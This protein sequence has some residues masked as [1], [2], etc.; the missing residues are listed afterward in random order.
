MEETNKILINKRLEDISK[1]IQT[2]NN[3]IQQYIQAI[4]ELL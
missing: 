1:E 2:S 4:K 3:T